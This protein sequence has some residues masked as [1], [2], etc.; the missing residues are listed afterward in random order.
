MGREL[1]LFDG[2][3]LKDPVLQ[4]HVTTRKSTGNLVGEKLPDHSHG[5]KIAKD[6]ERAVL[7]SYAGVCGSIPSAVLQEI[8]VNMLE[9]SVPGQIASA[10]SAEQI[11]MIPSQIQTT[12]E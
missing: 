4:L 9:S 8:S 3:V 5:K 7:E 1:A 11:V 6:T 12:L 2:G 10:S